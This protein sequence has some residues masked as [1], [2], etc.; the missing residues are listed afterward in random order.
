MCFA[1]QS[2]RYI[3]T[4]DSSEIILEIDTHVH[5]HLLKMPLTALISNIVII[6]HRKSIKCK[7]STSKGLKSLPKQWGLNFTTASGHA[8]LIQHIYIR[9]ITRYISENTRLL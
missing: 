3:F 7:S 1:L 6:V 5:I 2:I 9:Y 8:T 4:A